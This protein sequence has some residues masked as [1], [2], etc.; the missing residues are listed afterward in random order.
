MLQYTLA[1]LDR[2]NRRLDGL[3]SEQLVNQLLFSGGRVR[4]ITEVLRTEGELDASD[5]RTFVRHALIL[6]F[7]LRRVKRNSAALRRVQEIV[8]SGR[9]KR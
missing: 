9:N 3:T 1:D 7:A 5:S 4:Q 2:T 8:Y 6:A